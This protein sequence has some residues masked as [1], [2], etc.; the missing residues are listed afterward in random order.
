MTLLLA[1]NEKEAV[2]RS[3]IPLSSV[4]HITLIK[5]EAK[6]QCSAE[7]ELGSRTV[8]PGLA[9][10]GMGTPGRVGVSS[11]L[12]PSYP[13]P[14]RLLKGWPVLT[15]SESHCQQSQ[16]VKYETGGR[17]NEKLEVK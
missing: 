7:Q 3:R 12:P 15:P 10:Y 2:L 9:V 5:E 11:H 14:H 16:S 6:A 17:G 4:S 1:E 8:K 13:S